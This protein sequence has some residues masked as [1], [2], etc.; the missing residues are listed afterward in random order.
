M[1]NLPPLQP[2]MMIQ[3]LPYRVPPQLVPN[4]PV[5][6][7][8]GEHLRDCAG[9]VIA[10][11]QSQANNNAMRL[12]LYWTM[13]NNQFNNQMYMQLVADT[14]MLAEITY[15]SQNGQF[16]IASCIEQAATVLCKCWSVKV[17]SSHPSLTQALDQNGQRDFQQTVNQ[18]NQIDQ[19][20]NFAR[21]RLMQGG[22]MGGGM[23]MMGMNNGGNMPVAR[24]HMGVAGN[25]VMHGHQQMQMH[26]M[27]NGMGGFPTNQHQQ[28]QHNQGAQRLWNN[29]QKE[30]DYMLLAGTTIPEKK[31]TT[32]NAPAGFSDPLDTAVPAHMLA[33]G[34]AAGQKPEVIKKENTMIRIPSETTASGFPLPA[35]RD[36]FE[37]GGLKLV[38]SAFT[39]PVDFTK[40][41]PHGVLYDQASSAMFYNITDPKAIREVGLK[42]E[43]I[44]GMQPYEEH[45][46]HHLL[47]RRGLNKAAIPDREATRKAFMGIVQAND[48]SEELMI[49]DEQQ[50][51]TDD[52]VEKLMAKGPV[53]LENLNIG[54]PANP[55]YQAIFQNFLEENSIEIEKDVVVG[56]HYSSKED[57]AL[58][59]EAAIKALALKYSVRWHVLAKNVAELKELIHPAYWTLINTRLTDAVNE[60][61]QR[62]MGIDASIDNFVEDIEDLRNG[63]HKNFGDFALDTF[64]NQVR[65]VAL[66]TCLF[67]DTKETE[68]TSETLDM[69]RDPAKVEAVWATHED[70]YLLPCN[71]ED[72]T[73]GHTGKT[74][75]VTEKRTPELFKALQTH[76]ERQKG[77]SDSAA[78]RHTKLITQDGKG[79][80]FAIKSVYHEDSYQ[81]YSLR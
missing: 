47:G 34:V 54:G 76:F 36:V 22:G 11:L 44:G 80:I 74:G 1:Q 6:P 5:S 38:Y 3:G 58:S 70:I 48:I 35:P 66:T 39:G 17:A 61:L 13:A 24:S 15:Q 60:L 63:L 42:L 75:L 64:D 46:T 31:G 45:E 62:Y 20:I 59:G 56:F 43:D 19:Q 57:W 9:F 26:G 12:M 23:P 50:G 21:Q 51:G 41:C 68:E 53:I 14:A 71:A 30:D 79:V 81:V 69:S 40:G 8:M 73:L 16:P 32:I 33:G 77:D 10:T 25:A 18:A 52:V 55:V 27:P 72:I 67:T 65:R 7:Q 37:Y 78:V 2:N 49:R 28:H 29:N 4:V